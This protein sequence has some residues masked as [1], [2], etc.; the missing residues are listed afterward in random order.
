M[1]LNDAASPLGQHTGTS[2]ATNAVYGPAT[3]QPHSATPAQ[4]NWPWLH[5]QV[6]RVTERTLLSLC[7]TRME[8]STSRLGA[9]IGQQFGPCCATCEQHMLCNQRSCD[10]LLDPSSRQA[11]VNIHTPAESKV[12]W[13]S[14]CD[15]HHISINYSI[16]VSCF[17]HHYTLQVSHHMLTLQSLLR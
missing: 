14:T 10:R 15:T 3:M 5:S 4:L 11:V 1:L 13:L 8:Y 6:V 16:Y 12:N 17:I 2:G 9:L 7:H